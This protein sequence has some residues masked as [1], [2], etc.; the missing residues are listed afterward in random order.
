MDE[1]GGYRNTDP[2]T[3]KIAAGTI[4]TSRLQTLVLLVLDSARTPLNGWEIS[5]KLRLPTITVVPRLAPLRRSHYIVMAGVRKGP[6]NRM[7]LAYTISDKGR[8]M[9]HPGSYADPIQLMVIEALNANP[10]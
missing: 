9:L 1:E 7:Q 10:R 8:R 2:F 5:L 4:D 3:S 6:S